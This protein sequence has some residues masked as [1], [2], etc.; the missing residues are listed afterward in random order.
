MAS[1]VSLADAVVDSAFKIEINVVPEGPRFEDQL[2]ALSANEG[3]GQ[4]IVVVEVRE[5]LP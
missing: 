2:L 1:R 5:F 3:V 4:P